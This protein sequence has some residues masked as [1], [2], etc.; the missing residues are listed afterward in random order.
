[1]SAF[2]HGYKVGDKVEFY[3]GLDSWEG[4]YVVQED[5][6]GNHIDQSRTILF[7]LEGS[8]YRLYNPKGDNEMKV[9]TEKVLKEINPGVYT[10]SGFCDFEIRKSTKNKVELS[11]DSLFIW[12]KRDIKELIEA[13]QQIE[14]ALEDM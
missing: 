11:I 9:V 12:T 7:C 13:L 10:T 2:N 6:S 1:M 4:P 5:G 14:D 3:N 8:K